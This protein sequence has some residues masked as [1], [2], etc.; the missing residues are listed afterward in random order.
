MET[1][2]D[3]LANY[4]LLPVRVQN[5]LFSF[6]ENKDSYQECERLL[7]ELEPLGYTFEYYLDGVPYDLRKI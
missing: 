1:E 3:L 7:K 2:V 5:I 4:E 6:D